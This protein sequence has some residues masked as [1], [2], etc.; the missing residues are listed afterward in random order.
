MGG[1]VSAPV[2][3]EISDLFGVERV[4]NGTVESTHQGL[5]F[6][7]PTGTPV[8]AV[9]N[10]RVILAQPL[11]FEGNFVVID[12]GQGL[13]TLYLHLSKFPGKGRR[14]CEKRPADRAQRRHRPRD[15]AAPA[16]RGA[17]AGSV[18]ESAGAAEIKVAVSSR[19]VEG[20]ASRAR[21]S[22]TMLRL[23]L[24]STT[25]HQ[26]L[27]NQ[28]VAALIS[29]SQQHIVRLPHAVAKRNASSRDR[30][31]ALPRNNDSHQIQR[32]GSRDDDALALHALRQ[33]AVGAQRFNRDRKRELLSH[34]AIDKSAASN[35]ATIFEAAVAN[36]Q[37]A[38]ARQIGF[39]R[40]QIAEHDS[41][42]PQQHPAAGFDAAVAIRAFGVQQRPASRRMARPAD[43]SNPFP[44]RCPTSFSASPEPADFQIRRRSPVPPRPVPT[45][46]FRFPL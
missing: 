4:F 8:E 11:F 46:R 7:V 40:Q 43:F 19:F 29:R 42:A 12:H 24:F 37:F 34:K 14:R 9:N 17:L 33:P 3:A 44:D 26:A 38:P 25:M 21:P 41:I 45:I 23:A 15:R 30:G 31:N 1:V 2:N 5:D 35:L 16:S 13:L 22:I 27:N 6:R 36:L 10:G 32:I 18:F 28:A 39:A 20:R